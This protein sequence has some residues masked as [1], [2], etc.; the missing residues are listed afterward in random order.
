[1]ISRGM[2]AKDA[3]S[4]IGTVYTLTKEDNGTP[5]RD[6]REFSSLLNACGRMGYPGLGV[7]L[8][9]GDRGEALK[10][11][12]NVLSQYRRKLAEYLEW[13]EK[14]NFVKE[15]QHLQYFN[16]ENI[17]D[18]RIIGTVTSIAISSRMLKSDRPVVALAYAE[19]NLTK[20]SIRATDELVKKGINLGNAIRDA[21]LGIDGEA[22][23]G[24]HDIAAGAFI[25]KGCEDAFLIRLEDSVKKQLESK[26]S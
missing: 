26:K 5:L 22:E 20:V 4:V 11:T 9:M 18:D 19:D 16:A 7:V 25:A 15:T 8:C 12:Q 1:M 10:E 23:G 3:E 13:I 14:P 2:D 21:I 17:M 6:A 24:G